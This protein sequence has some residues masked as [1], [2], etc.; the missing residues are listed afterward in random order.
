MKRGLGYLVVLL[1]LWAAAAASAAPGAPGTEIE[2]GRYLSRVGN[3]MGCH[4]ARG[5]ADYAGGRAIDTPFGSVYSPN[6]TPDAAT[7]L[8]QWNADDFWRALHEGR[9]RGG[10]LLNPAFPYP[11]YSQVTRADADAL[12][13]Y[14]Q[15][16]PPVVQANQ[17]HALRFPFSTQ[18]ALWAWRKAFFRPAVFQPQPEQ[19]AEWNRGAYL[20]QG[21]G[22]CGACH[23]PRNALGAARSGASLAGG[24]VPVQNW[25]APAL[26]DEREA[27]VASWPVAEIARLLQTGVAERGSVLGPMADV[28]AGGTQH[29]SDA[30]ARAM[31]VYLKALAPAPATA[32]QAAPPVPA[33]LSRVGAKLYEKHC[34]DCHG[35]SGQGEPGAFPALAGNRAV[36]LD[37]P[38]NLLRA[39]LQGGYAPSTAGNPR[40]HGMPPFQ[41]VLSNDEMAAVASFVRS[42]WGNAA[43]PVATIEVYRAR[44]RRAP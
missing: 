25:Y 8:G 23:T 33:N 37:N 11:E 40:P 16:L 15:T 27:G 28:V 35:T 12:F 34:A 10:R 31:A 38:G 9:S 4:T 3:C 14:L 5:G 22:H 30:D 13:A 21:L 42:A 19:S 44:E 20:V 29:L 39:I 36:V 18:A 17:P 26:N 7:G 24:V 43:A 41:H 6:I 32:R 2:R 1:G